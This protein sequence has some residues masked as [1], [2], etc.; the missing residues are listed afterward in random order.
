[1]IHMLS[2]N[3]EITV[4]SGFLGAG[5]TTFI[6]EFIKQNQNSTDRKFA[7]LV[8]EF[9]DVPVDG[10]VLRKEG[11]EIIELPSGCIC[12]SLRMSLPDT[13]DRIFH[14]I[15]PDILLIEPSG[16]ATPNSV[17]DAIKNCKNV[18]KYIIK[19]L[20]CVVDA[21]VFNELIDDFGEFY[22]K[23][24]ASAD[25]VLINKIDLVDNYEIEKT[26]RKIREINPSALTVRTS[27]CRFIPE[28]GELSNR[29]EKSDPDLDIFLEA[30]SISPVRDFTH[31][32]LKTVLQDA[33]N[34]KFGKVLR[35][36]G[37]VRCE[38]MHLFQI[39]GKNYR[40]EMWD[41]N[42]KIG[43]TTKAVFIGN[44]LNKESLREVFGR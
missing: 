34:G 38:G 6:Q 17:I 9:G 1:M 28:G 18:E 5:K 30:V 37:F 44:S 43:V 29:S 26:E 15:N 14:E 42:E 13:V 8:N 10:D 21:S 39:S 41:E 40:I 4:V 22:V 32:E 7:V 16:I 24:I 19:P 31:N 35:A 27:Y 36:K 3:M 33:V 12:C 11:L 23:Q 25:V 2:D 20:I